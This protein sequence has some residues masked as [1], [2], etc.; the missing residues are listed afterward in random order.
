MKRDLF[1]KKSVK[2]E[3]TTLC[4]LCFNKLLRRPKRSLIKFDDG[5]FIGQHF[6]GSI[7]YAL[8]ESSCLNARKENSQ[9]ACNDA[10]KLF[11]AVIEFKLLF[12]SVC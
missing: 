12:L 6:F 9:L 1:A 4:K 3:S 2:A 8:L 10:T 5:T 7:F 11:I